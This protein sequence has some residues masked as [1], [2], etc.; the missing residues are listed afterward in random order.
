MLYYTLFSPNPLPSV[1]H[2]AVEY[3][4]SKS[5][6]SR[7]HESLGDEHGGGTEETARCV[8]RAFVDCAL[9]MISRAAYG[10]YSFELHWRKFFC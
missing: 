2:S 10:R 1:V 3:H 7:L 5:S 4:S 9:L 8:S 6:T